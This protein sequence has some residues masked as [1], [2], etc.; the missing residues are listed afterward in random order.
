MGAGLIPQGFAQGNAA[1][2][3]CDGQH[4]GDDGQS[5]LRLSHIQKQHSI[6]ITG[7][8]EIHMILVKAED[9]LISILC[10]VIAFLPLKN[11]RQLTEG[12]IIF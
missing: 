9:L 8:I 6:V 3:P 5:F 10:L 2:L 7:Y 11:D 4:L 12:G 1:L